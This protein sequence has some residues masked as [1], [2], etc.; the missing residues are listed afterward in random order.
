MRFD[1][2]VF[3]HAL[4]RYPHDVLTREWRETATL[5]DQ[6]G[7]TTCWLGEHH[8]WYA[9]HHVACPNPVLVGMHIVGANPRIRVGQSACV[10]PDHHPIRL[11]E[12]L[13]ML[14]QMSEGRVDVGIARG[15][16]STASIQFRPHADRRDPATNYRLF[17]ETLDI[18]LGCWT[19]KAFTHQ[20][21]F[22]TFPVPGWSEKNPSVYENDP[23]YGP[24]GELI[25]LGVTPETY[26]KPYPPIWQ[27]ADSTVSY[28]YAAR[29]GHAVIGVART[30]EGTREAW[31]RYQAVASQL[32][33]RELPLGV[34]ANGQTLNL[35][36]TF[37]IAETYEEAARQARP[38]I[39]AFWEN[40][41]G[42]NV[43]WARERFTASDE[44]LSDEDRNLD[45]FDFMQKYEILWIGS[46]EHVIERID[47]LRSEINCQHVTIWPNPNYVPYRDVR[48]S[49]E[50]F[51][52]RV[53]P[54]F[55]NSQAGMSI[56]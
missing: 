25:A 6:G 14:D 47:K 13:A 12:D 22:Y 55:E 39:N 11:A 38:G 21:E 16:N 27:A 29:R 15:T 30:L 35:M 28:E 5:L 18:L 8:F 49:I 9:G 51:A 17:D 33:G 20:G 10:L 53:I 46:P 23:H 36:R 3:Y 7:F 34:C 43:N 32:W 48:R 42:V 56:A 19:E 40:A 4:E 37:Y 52:E 54:A 50:M 26:Q 1:G 2:N 31:T 41:V 44:T 24:D 45:W